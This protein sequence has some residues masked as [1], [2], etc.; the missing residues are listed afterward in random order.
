MESSRRISLVSIFAVATAF[1][2]FSGL[3]AY[4]YVTLFTDRPQ[5]FHLLLA[6]NVTYWYAWAVLVPG[7]LWMARR[8]RFGRHT[9]KRAAAA[10]VVA[11]IVF[12]LSHA[13]MM[14]T[15]RVLIMKVLAGRDVSWWMYFQE[16][17][18]LNFDWEMMTYWAVV[19][20][21]HALDFHRES[22]ERELTEAQ[23]RTRLAEAQLQALQRQLHPH[24][25]F[26]TL[27]TISALMHR[28]TEAADAMLERLSDLLRLSLDRVGTQHMPL[29]DELDFLQKY[30]EIEK[31]RFGDR[32]QVQIDVASD[33]LDALVPNLVLQ[34]LVEN[35]LR[36]GIGPKIG[37]GRVDI[38]A[39]H[40]G[41]SLTLEVRDN[42]VGMPPDTL[43]KFSGVGLRNTRSRLQ[44][45]YGSNHRFEV[46]SPS[47]VGLAV[48]IVIP[49]VSETA[50]SE[51][52][53][54]SPSSGSP[55]ESVA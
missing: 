46:K 4:N 2:I 52:S 33:T 21:S 27:N 34:P 10:H 43:D 19:G 9:W 40:A 24:F 48:T 31:T 15:S 54:E 1:G 20:L 53:S 12:T 44:H 41:D 14:V 7:M 38:V 36:H 3:Q 25:L 6:L 49:F 17:F 51:S 37:G 28:D 8:Y 13:V 42:G 55:M 39:S 5:P 18:F 29:S 50:M 22:R 11:V 47:G 16:L 23:L 32:L 35:A 30:L 26:N 45:L